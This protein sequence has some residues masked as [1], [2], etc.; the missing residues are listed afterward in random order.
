MACAMS[1]DNLFRDALL[2]ATRVDDAHVNN[3]I[4]RPA[5]Y[6][7]GREYEPRKVIEDWALGF[8]LGN[9]LKYISRAGRKGDAAEDLRKAVQYLEWEIERLE[10]TT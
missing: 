3:P 5:H 8:H 2:K 9:A 4:T 7:D 10:R 1:G 6:I